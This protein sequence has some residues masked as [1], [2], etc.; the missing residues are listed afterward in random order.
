MVASDGTTEKRLILETITLDI[1]DTENEIMAG[2]APGGREVTVVAGMAEPET[3][4]I[5]FVTADPVTGAWSADFKSI[6]FDITEEMRGPSFAQIHDEDGDANE[7][8]TPAAP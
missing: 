8:G 4:G 3:Q 7:A 6:G 1:F 2:T 5:I